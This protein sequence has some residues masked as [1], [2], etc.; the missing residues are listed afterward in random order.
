MRNR[1]LAFPVVLSLTGLVVGCTAGSDAHELRDR[2]PWIAYDDGGGVDLDVTEE[3]DD[4]VPPEEPTVTTDGDT[5]PQQV[6]LD[7]AY[8]LVRAMTVSEAVSASCSTTIVA[9]LSAQLIDEL[10]CL[11]PG[12]MGTLAGASNIR[13]G[14]AASPSLQ[15]PAAAALVRASRRRSTPLSMNS[16]L[17]TLAQ[18]YLLYRWAGAR[19]GVRVAAAPGRSNHNGGLAIDIEDNAGWRRSL[20]AEGFRWLGSGDPV[21]FDYVGAGAIDIRSLSVQ[22]FQ[23]LWNRNHPEDRIAVDGAYGPATE[24]RLRQSPATGFASAASCGAP[25]PAPAPTPM[26]PPAPTPAPTPAP[27]PGGASCTHSF[28]GD[29]ASGACSA[30]YQ[31][32]DG[33]WRTRGGCGSCLCVESSGGT[34]CGT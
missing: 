2:A 11:R 33:A 16:G 24:S 25:A 12:T 19:C 34:G 26:P 13:R 29:Y 28:G 4:Y 3:H 15:T 30:S 10:E 23:R 21:H 6:P 1:G 14:A 17:R 7:S 27:A 18:Q 5:G 20:E 9:G 31:C 8:A 22:A 32:C